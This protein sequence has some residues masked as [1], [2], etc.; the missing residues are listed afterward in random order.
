MADV[1]GVRQNYPKKTEAGK[2]KKTNIKH[3]FYRKACCC[4]ISIKIFNLD[5][6]DRVN[7]HI[8]ENLYLGH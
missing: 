3:S 7:A 4:S 1:M 6:F 2:V 8:A 5:N